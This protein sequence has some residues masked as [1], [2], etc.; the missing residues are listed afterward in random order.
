M[1]KI[2]VICC[3]PEA[4]TDISP[5]ATGFQT[6]QPPTPTTPIRENEIRLA[7]IDQGAGC[8][9]TD[10]RFIK[11]LSVSVSIIDDKVIKHQERFGA[12]F[13]YTIIHKGY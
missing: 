8:A 6:Q 12:L 3:W 1:G 11:P 10:I 7:T 9:C 4:D 2:V 13:T 5:Y